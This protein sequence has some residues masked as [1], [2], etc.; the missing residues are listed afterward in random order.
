MLCVEI[1]KQR[2]EISDAEWQ[3]FLSAAASL[4]KVGWGIKCDVKKIMR[5]DCWCQRKKTAA[6]AF[7]FLNYIM[8]YKC[9]SGKKKSAFIMFSQL[10]EKEKRNDYISLNVQKWPSVS[11]EI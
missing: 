3:L 8:R 10:G 5:I 1:M 9:I 6:Y 4:E 11:K 2:D 7:F